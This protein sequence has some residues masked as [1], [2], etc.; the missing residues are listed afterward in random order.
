[1]GKV[2]STVGGVIIEQVAA[3]LIEPFKE[4]FFALRSFFLYA[5]LFLCI[6]WLLPT[7]KEWTRFF[8]LIVVIMVTIRPV[9]KAFTQMQHI[10]EQLM[11]VYLVLSPLLTSSLLLGSGI[12]S[13]LSIS[14]VFLIFLQTILVVVT[15]YLIP[16][17]IATFVFDFIT[18]MLPEL[19]FAKMS[20]FLRMSVLSVVSVSVLIYTMLLATNGVLVGAF[21]GE[22][23]EPVKRLLQQNIPIIGSLVTE[24]LNTFKKYSSTAL[25]TTSTGLLVSVWSVTIL[26]TLNILILGFCYRFLAAVLEP[27]TDSKVNGLIEDVSKTLFILCAVSFLIAFAYF[28][29]IMMV[30]LMVQMQMGKGGA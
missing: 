19:S 3:F 14:P 22:I 29:T 15:K 28:F 24:S 12:F 13:V 23:A 18:R 20:D 11:D 2:S 17:L 21:S 8:F 9:F 27:F 6:N 30:V 7:M 1:M 26:P 25:I 4:Q 5:I 16:M 10:T